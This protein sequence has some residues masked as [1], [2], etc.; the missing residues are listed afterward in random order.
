MALYFDKLFQSLGENANT[1]STLAGYFMAANIK[2]ANI[3]MDVTSFVLLFYGA[4]RG[5]RVSCDF[6]MY[7]LFIVNSWLSVTR[8]A[9]TSFSYDRNSANKGV[10]HCV[11]DRINSN[12]NVTAEQNKYAPWAIACGYG[13]KNK[14]KK[15]PG[16]EKRRTFSERSC[17]RTKG[18]LDN[19]TF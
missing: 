6:I 7:I 13:D 11:L 12:L 18:V 14:V 9:N 15:S 2:G 16:E 8:S 10:S 5:G 4:H 19:F 17:A 3:E 1:N